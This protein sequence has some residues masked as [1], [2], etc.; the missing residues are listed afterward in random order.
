M[1]ALVLRGVLVSKGNYFTGHVNNYN[2]NVTRVE[3]TS[4][5]WWKRACCKDYMAKVREQQ[6]MN[7]G[8]KKR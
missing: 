3:G 5:W 7:A 4:S 8:G 6:L 2:K 1:K